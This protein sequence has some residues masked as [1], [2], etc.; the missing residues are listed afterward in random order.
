MVS[1]T[2]HAA[3]WVFTTLDRG[4]F[5]NVI[6]GIIIVWFYIVLTLQYGCVWMGGPIHVIGMTD[7]WVWLAHGPQMCCFSPLLHCSVDVL[8]DSVS[9]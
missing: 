8:G 9:C 1:T 4:I 2:P 3:I 6:S 5:H 7:R